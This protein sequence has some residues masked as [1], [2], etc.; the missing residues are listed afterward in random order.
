VA[1]SIGKV[2]V[3]VGGGGRAAAG[4]GRILLHHGNML[5]VSIP[6]EIFMF[7]NMKLSSVPVPKSSPEIGK[8]LLNRSIPAMWLKSSKNKPADGRVADGFVV[9]PEGTPKPPPR[10]FSIP[11]AP[12]PTPKSDGLCWVCRCCCWAPISEPGESAPPP[13]TGPLGCNPV[14]ALGVAA[15]APPGL[16][17]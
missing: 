10:P 12:T 6:S 5:L 4:Q 9:A 15:P 16:L 1:S 17:A 7:K 14:F 11:T 8:L 2:R 3:G 13:P